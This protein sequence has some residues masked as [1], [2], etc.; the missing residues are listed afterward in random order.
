MAFDG[1]CDGRACCFCLCSALINTEYIRDG[2][3]HVFFLMGTPKAI[4]GVTSGAEGSIYS[5]VPYSCT[6]EWCFITN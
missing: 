5:S 3:I 2:N 1:Y 4:I 6:V